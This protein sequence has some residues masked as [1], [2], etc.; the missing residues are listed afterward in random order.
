MTIK[1]LP[2]NAKSFYIKCKRVWQILTKPTKEEFKATTKISAISIIILGIVGFII[3]L[4]V[5]SI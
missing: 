5:T 2:V 4:I 1:D 3:S